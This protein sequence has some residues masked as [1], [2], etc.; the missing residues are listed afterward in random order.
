MKM[1]ELTN[2]TKNKAQNCILSEQTLQQ[3]TIY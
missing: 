1:R 2:Y 3:T